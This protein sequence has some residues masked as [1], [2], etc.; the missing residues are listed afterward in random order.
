MYAGLDVSDKSTHIC[1]VDGDG[2]VLRRDVVASDPEVLAKWLVKHCAD[3]ARV[4]LETGP[5]STFLYHGLVERAVPIDCICARHAKGVLA[6]RVNKSDVHDAEGLAQLARTGWF[7]RVHMKAS[8]THIDRAALR[9][10]AQLIT[11]RVAMGNQLRG[12]LKLFGLRLGAARTPGKRRERL[13]AL[14]QQRPDLEPLFAPLVASMEVIE[15]Q[16]R[17]SN[18]LLESRAE[19]DP[20]CSRLMSVP[21]VGPITALTFT[22]S[23]EDPHRFARSEDV[24]AYAGLVP[25]RSQSGERDVRGNISKAG[26]AM[27]RRSLYEAVN[28]ML[29]RVQRPFALQQWGQRIAESKGNKRARIAVA[30]KLAVLLHSLWL[31][32]TEF[33]WQ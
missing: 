15:E 27:L 10:R 20:V 6:A 14:Y 1:V 2:T 28:I 24:G 8:A 13:I 25:R 11:T 5:L 21:G 32:E 7:K 18:R 31:N 12:L 16:L 23:V 29:C 4:V 3:L 33:R 17:A 30:R 9:I 22:A 26:D 19:E